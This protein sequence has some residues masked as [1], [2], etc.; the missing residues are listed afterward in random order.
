ML[1]L[2]EDA[3]NRFF[4][5]LACRLGSRS[6]GL[7]V[8]KVGSSRAIVLGIKPFDHN[9]AVGRPHGWLAFDM[10]ALKTS[11]FETVLVAATRKTDDHHILL[12]PAGSYVHRF[13]DRVGGLQS[14]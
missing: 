7:A 12:G 4:D 6:N 2:A 14:G 10:L 11:H 3:S 5:R 1:A 13:H 8:G 9:T